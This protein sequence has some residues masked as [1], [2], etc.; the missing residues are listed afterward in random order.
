M[1]MTQLGLPN[2]LSH[3]DEDG[4][5]HG[6]L[7][8]V[9]TAF[10]KTLWPGHLR[11][12]DGTVATTVSMAVPGYLCILPIVNYTLSPHFLRTCRRTFCGLLPWGSI[13]SA[14]RE[15][16]QGAVTSTGFHSFR[17]RCRVGV[18]CIVPIRMVRAECEN[19]SKKS[20]TEA[21]NKWT[22]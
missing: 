17:V 8:L 18:E 10:S 20:G 7:P 12:G 4:L 11:Q 9:R 21:G 3:L 2:G 22:C 1:R 13:V 5:R 6:I 15:R 14:G 16:T 19:R